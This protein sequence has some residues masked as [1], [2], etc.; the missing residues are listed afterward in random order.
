MTP[1]SQLSCSSL[2]RFRDRV[3]VWTVLGGTGWG[4]MPMTLV[5][6][7][8]ACSPGLTE[9]AKSHAKPFSSK[10]APL[11]DDA[12]DVCT[13]WSGSTEPWAAQERQITA[14]R[15]QKSDIVAVG[16]V[17][18]IVTSQ[19]SGVRAQIALQFEVSTLLRGTKPDLPDGQTRVSLIVSA[20]EDPRLA[21]RL[22]RKKAI[23][24][25]RWLPGDNPPF[26]WHL[27]CATEGVSKL[28]K[29]QLDERAKKE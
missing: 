12:T 21:R 19:V 26:R 13:P 28:V 6:I 10:L 2:P 4:L 24:F 23:L 3:R 25:L 1:T 15:S 9:A 29:T 7:F 27:T 17:Q 5:L 22:I 16:A 11:F 20:R 18:E 8:S 14:L